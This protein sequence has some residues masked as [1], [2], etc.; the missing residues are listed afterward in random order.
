MGWLIRSPLVG[1][2]ILMA[3]SVLIGTPAPA[4]SDGVGGPVAV[5]RDATSRNHPPFLSYVGTA[6]YREEL[7]Q[8]LKWPD[9]EFRTDLTIDLENQTVTVVRYWDD[10][11]LTWPWVVSLTGYR[12]Q[13]KIYSHAAVFR[14]K[15]RRSKALAQGE[16]A[17]GAFNI[18]LPVRF[19][20]TL[21]RIIGQGANIKVT[22]SESITFSGETQFFIK[23]RDNESGGQRRFPELDM[24]QQLQVNLTGT[25]GEKVKVEMQHNS[26]SQVPL[27][28]RIKLR[29][30]GFEDE[31]IQ[32]IEVGNTSL[33]LPGNQFVSLS[34]QQQGL[35]G[36]KMIGQAGKL[37]F[38]AVFSQQQGQTDSEQ[39]VGGSSQIENTIQDF[40]YIRGRYFVVNNYDAVADIRVFVDDNNGNNTTGA[41]L[42]GNGYLFNSQNVRVENVP[43]IQG[44]YDELIEWEDYII[45][46]EI[47][48]LVMNTRLRNNDALAIW[49][50]AGSG[51]AIDTVGFL[52]DPVPVEFAAG[53]SVELK[54]IRPR[55]EEYRH[56]NDPIS[57]NLA[58]SPTWFYQ[59]RNVYDLRGRNI[60]PDGL[61]IR[62]YQKA[63][64]AGE[65]TDFQGNLSFFEI[66]GLDLIGQT[67]SEP[68]DGL[69]DDIYRGSEIDPNRLFPNAS[70]DSFY[71]NRGLPLGNLPYRLNNMLDATNGV[72]FF[73][74]LYP[75]DPAYRHVL[76]GSDEFPDLVDRN[77]SIYLQNDSRNA[78]NLYEIVVRFRASAAS[79]SLGRSNI[80]EG[81]EVVRLNGRTLARGR[82]YRI[83]YEIGQIEF[84]GESK[85]E[86]LE[87]NAD[88]SIDFEYAPFL[89]QSQ[90]SLAGAA[91]T[92]NLSDATKLSSILMFKGKRTPFRRPRLGQE[93]SRIFVS[94][95]SLATQKEPGFLTDWADAIPGMDARERSN[96]TINL[97]GAATFPNPNTKNAIYLDD[98]EGT[99]EVSS[100]GITRRQWD[101]ASIPK[102][103]DGES[104]VR[105][106]LRFR[107]VEWYNPKNSTSRGDLNPDLTEDEKLKFIPVLEVAVN[108]GTIESGAPDDSA[109]G[110]VMRLVSK[111]GLALKERKF[112]EVWVNDF[113]TGQGKMH[114]DMGLLGEDQ[115][116]SVGPPNDSLD[117]ED[118]NRDGVLDDSGT[119]D[120]DALNGDE[121]TGLDGIFDTQGLPEPIDDNWAFDEAVQN[122]F[123]HINGT[124]DNGFLDTEDLNGNG[125]LDEERSFFRYTVDFSTNEN[126]G[127]RGNTTDPGKNWLLYRI[128]LAKGEGRSIGA[129]ASPSLDQGVKYVRIWFSDVGATE[130]R[131]QIASIEITGNRWLEG[132]IQNADGAIIL[133]DSAE[134]S[135]DELFAA[136]V[137]NNKDDKSYD[138]PPV[139]IQ[140]ERGIPEREQSLFIQYENLKSG[141]TG[142]VFR[143]LFE[144]ED[145][146][147]YEKLE[148]WAR[149]ANRSLPT[150]PEQVT[151]PVPVLFFRFGGDSLNFYEVR[152]TLDALPGSIGGRPPWDRIEV[153]LAEITRVKLEEPDS[154]S[155]YGVRLPVREGQFE[156]R[157]IRAVGN[158][159]MTKVRRLSFG[160]TNPLVP[161]GQA[162]TDTIWVDDLRLT[163]V[164]G[165]VGYAARV[166]FNFKVSDLMGVRGEFRKVGKEFRRV[167]G[168]GTGGRITEEHPRSGSDD[169]ELTLNGNVNLTKFLQ[170]AGVKLP[171]D[172]GFSKSVRKPEL[173]NASDILLD[174]PESEKTVKNGRNVGVSLGRTRKSPNPLLYYTTDAMNL[175]MSGAR[176]ENTTPVSADTSWS[177][178]MDWSYNYSPRFKSDLPVFRNWV[179]NPLPKSA[180]LTASRKR[181]ESRRFDIR[182][183]RTTI[184]ETRDSRSVLSFAMAPV[185][186]GGFTSD[187]NFS[188]TRD[189]RF[190]EPL[191]GFSHVN[192]GF[193]TNR[194]HESRLSYTPG[195]KKY[196]SWLNPRLSYNTKFTDNHP[197][198]TNL[199]LSDNTQIRS[200][201][202]NNSNNSR[203]DF[204]VGIS[205][206]FK[207]L[208]GKPAPV[209]EDSAKGSGGNPMSV[210]WFIKGLGSRI[211]DVSG[212]ISLNRSSSFAQL[213]DRPSL[214]YQFG[215]ES[216]I[217]S[218]LQGRSTNQQPQS[219]RTRDVQTRA[220]SSI[221]MPAD[222][223]LRWS[224]NRSTRR[225][226]QNS[227]ATESQSTTWPDLQ[228]SWSGWHKIGKLKDVLK[229]GN[230]D[231][232]Y[233]Q[234]KDLAG[235][236]LDDLNSERISKSWAPLAEIDAEWQN[237]LQS[238]VSV[239]RTED[240]N[241]N[242]RGGQ[243]E[244]RSK[245]LG[246]S[247]SLSYRKTS[248]KKINIPI[249]GKGRKGGTFTA[250]TTFRLSLNFSSNKE[251]RFDP[252][253]PPKLEGHTRDFSIAPSVS[254]SWL[255]NLTGN[256][257]L[258]FGE[259][260][261][262]KNENRSTRSIGASISALFKF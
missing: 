225:S 91:F 32:R 44:S 180:T 129:S 11:P 34:S 212:S 82:D 250:T 69:L 68:P 26:E 181:G 249:L 233:N 8:R 96:L 28:N 184:S 226:E 109:W 75:F 79:F 202:I 80:L 246:V 104:E 163:G 157:S 255:Q 14:D 238:R 164:K 42:P 114:I 245:S 237:G 106:S 158:P 24:R 138:P 12:E 151:R 66:M 37:D 120:P 253:A 59:L 124:E 18:D 54:V 74:D 52:P 227:N 178:N 99:E 137:I 135:N 236:T 242:L 61:D 251:E 257:E 235:R 234:R 183:G 172:W 213:T 39:F 174:D 175:R 259:R 254:W 144:D 185:T 130:A 43:G 56:P 76:Q 122:D 127:A 38:T 171:V 100:F 205:K 166:G 19:P 222:M 102:R 46:R 148:F 258:R 154:I 186:G 167:T 55:T 260:R 220:S 4:I 126:V 86:A 155:L 105:D 30:E 132:G 36:V 29:Y 22:G 193:E 187:F 209:P 67:P 83:V 179:V 153:D 40:E 192:R 15:N 48:L 6:P 244:N 111:S 189:H 73:P 141:H 206:L 228:Y 239:D 150:S 84:L 90:R 62:I 98:M 89:A 123:S 230:L 218:L 134:F 101:L 143:R 197:A 7:A 203:M 210:V 169:T 194:N 177:L 195:F 64:G 182:T 93:P 113:G 252:G 65:R 216:E 17:A 232:G 201:Q 121:D 97:E 9:G 191:P 207:A 58:Y 50:T 262:L 152:D 53:D 35:F 1:Q 125:L 108:G 229:N 2:C 159:S 261:N 190:G 147:R 145:Y 149:R 173:K 128:P 208:P 115:M 70:D 94:G 224:Y 107:A 160:V 133:P 217:D 146:T 95:F 13:I 57:P 27:E 81:S 116:W 221:G 87:E 47:G 136:G 168:G 10:V 156:G 16:T 139:E 161:G 223:N 88:V 118:K 103:A 23:E 92:Y 117:T 5:V 119:N 20:K 3:L 199:T 142:T 256:L 219:N 25:I 71:V 21:S 231:I 214:A 131:F 243:S 85:D 33:A 204:S 112:I 72:L 162:A 51:T 215:L 165:D 240:I 41:Q 140:E 176:N 248:R 247:G 196:L 211:G 198:N 60:Q 188:S 78:Q 170:G 200:H 77:P 110:G 49:Y 63:A 45:Q 241:R 31:I